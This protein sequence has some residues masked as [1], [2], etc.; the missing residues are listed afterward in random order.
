MAEPKSLSRDVL[1]KFLPDPESIRRFE[2]LFYVVSELT[3][4]EIAALSKLVQE[5][6]IDANSAFATAQSALSQIQVLAQDVGIQVGVTDSKASEALGALNRIAD[7]LQ[8]LACAPVQRNDNSFKTDYIDVSTTAPTAVGGITG[9]LKW[10]DTDG[11]LDLGLKGGNVTLQIGQENVLIVKN[12][13]AT[14]LTDGEVVY[15]SGASGANLL[16]KRALADSDV[17]SAST[18]G[19]V[20]ESIAV[21]GQGFITTFGQVR[22]LNTNSFNE[23]DILY[24]SPTVAGQITDVKPVA[25][26]H[27]VTVG[28]CTKKSAG[29]GE[30]FVRVDN[31]YELEELHN[32]LI[33]TPVLAGSLLVYDATTQVWKNARLTPGS[34]VTIT[35][36][37][38]SI[39]LAVAGAPPTGAAGGVLSGT[40]P[41]PGFAVDMATQAE[42]DAHTG[43]T[44]ASV[45]GLG[46]VSTLASDTDGTLA[47]N[48][49]L[50]VAT[51]R[52]VKTYVDG[53]VT[54][55]LDFKGNLNC[56]A[57]PNYPAGLK[58]DTYAVSVAGKIGGASG[59]S[60]EVGDMIVASADNAGGTQAAVGSSWFIMEHNLVGALL[61]ANNLYYVAKAA[62]ASS[63]LGLAIGTNVQAWDADLDAIAALVGTS[64]L[65][66]KT[67]S[68][69]W[70][71][72]TAAYGNVVGPASATDNALV[73][74]DATTGKL[75]Q[76]SV[77]TLSDAGALAGLTQLDVD[78]I[79]VDGNIISSTN[80]NGDIDLQP[81]GT[82]VV[83]STGSFRT[84]KQVQFGTSGVVSNAKFGSGTIGDTIQSF[85][86]TFDAT[87]TFA[88]AMVE[89]QFTAQQG[90]I[91]PGFAVNAKKWI[92]SLHRYSSAITATTLNSEADSSVVINNANYGITLTPSV[93]II[94]ATEARFDVAVT[95]SGLL[96]VAGFDYVTQAA[97]I[98]SQPITVT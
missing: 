14:P 15:V 37:D 20:T 58:G 81:N 11:T 63:N 17:T 70:S 61:S 52:A 66:R 27:M 55:L 48:S 75:V 12:N 2:K 36:A 59:I 31:G 30:I 83:D 50:R 90:F 23:G 53:A 86:F 38:G 26:Q 13:E 74:F 73:R 47:A 62:T 42:L 57:N 43:A 46:T 98:S 24:L 45:H 6:S 78:N 60:V 91:A 69:T 29:N 44:G 41:N 54:G 56:S 67:A 77:A 33:T 25:P 92:F 9:R 51:Q 88:M 76:N 79:R 1:A 18:L 7:S 35:N 8:A 64:G 80:T 21:N 87:K 93:T 96:S 97:I 10:N 4:A 82:G 68:N 22:G 32:V 94:S 89:I 95:N 39:T 19:V 65:L 34:N 28:Y 71:L 84:T 49:D 5:A 3:P 72:D 16:V 40:Y 85:T